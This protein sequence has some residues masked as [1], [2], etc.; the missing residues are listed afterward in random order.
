VRPVAVL[1][2]IVDSVRSRCTDSI[3]QLNPITLRRG[4]HVRVVDGPFRDFEAIFENYLS[5]TKRVA[6]LMKSIEGCGVRVRVDA[7]G[8]VRLSPESA[9]LIVPSNGI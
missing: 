4:E 9:S 5:G 7:S 6:I 3:I 2:A 1:E 8:V